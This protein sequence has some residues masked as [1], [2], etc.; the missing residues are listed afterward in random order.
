[1]PTY[2]VYGIEER[3]FV[4]DVEANDEAEAMRL[5]EAGRWLDSFEYLAAGEIHAESA[6]LND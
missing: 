3:R 2:S 6:E 4:V 1:M 5:V